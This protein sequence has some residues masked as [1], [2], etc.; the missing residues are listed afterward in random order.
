MH[1]GV[2]M[3]EVLEAIGTELRLKLESV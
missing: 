1:A 3:G 2:V